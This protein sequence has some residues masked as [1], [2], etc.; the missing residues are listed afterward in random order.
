MD[1]DEIEWEGV[2]WIHLAQNTNQRWTL[3]N[4]GM[5]FRVL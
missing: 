4:T 3:V 5:N 2:Y 1:C